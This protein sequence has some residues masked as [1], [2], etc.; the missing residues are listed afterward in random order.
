MTFP[1]LRAQCDTKAEH[2]ADIN[3]DIQKDSP[4]RLSFLLCY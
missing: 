3:A 4:E 2:K 1:T